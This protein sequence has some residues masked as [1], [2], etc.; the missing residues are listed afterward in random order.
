[1]NFTLTPIHT[2][3]SICTS[4]LKAFSKLYNILISNTYVHRKKCVDTERE[5]HKYY[6][7][8]RNCVIATNSARLMLNIFHLGLTNAHSTSNANKT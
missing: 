1:M 6:T 2:C 7:V 8:L 3:R 4:H 5:E